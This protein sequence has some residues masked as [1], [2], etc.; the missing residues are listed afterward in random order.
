[1]STLERAESPL[2]NE[3]FS[4]RFDSLPPEI[5]NMII[6]D[7]IACSLTEG[8]SSLECTYLIPQ[9]CWKQAIIQIPFLWDLENEIVEWKDQE[10]MAGSFE[11][12]WEKLARQILLE[13]PIF[14]FKAFRF[15][16]QLD[17]RRRIWQI[18]ME[19]YPNDVGMV[20]SMD[21]EDEGAHRGEGDETDEGGEED[22]EDEDSESESILHDH[23]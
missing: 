18:L 21:E 22:Q 3:G 20:N 5:R 4:N 10:A 8:S 2:T 11:W 9:Y 19:M 13:I 17:N 7:L 6:E 12:N 23:D 1:M 16:P 14:R 15:P